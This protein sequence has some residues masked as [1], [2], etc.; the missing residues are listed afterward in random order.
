MSS[1]DAADGLRCE[2]A[3]PTE[4]QPRPGARPVLRDEHRPALTPPALGGVDRGAFEPR[5][6]AGTGVRPVHPAHDA[7]V[8]LPEPVAQ[9]RLGRVDV[10]PL[11]AQQRLHAA[12][13]RRAEVAQPVFPLVL[14]GRHEFFGHPVDVA[15]DD[16]GDEQPGRTDDGRVGCPPG[17][18][19]E[20]PVLEPSCPDTV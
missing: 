10:D 16:L 18:L 14:V 2:R 4:R 8:M 11:T 9:D 3:L 17:Q 20:A 12:V 7:D 13:A 5:E 19:L 6:R 1:S 15:R